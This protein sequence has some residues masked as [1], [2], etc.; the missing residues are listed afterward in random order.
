MEK[1]S[2]MEEIL[3]SGKAELKRLK[4]LYQLLSSYQTFTKLLVDIDKEY[5][6][7]DYLR[8]INFWPDC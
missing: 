1:L 3:L 6:N 7:K 5:N 4:E 8:P 2:K